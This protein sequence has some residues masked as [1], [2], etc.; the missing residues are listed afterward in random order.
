[1]RAV[2]ASRRAST[3]ARS[4]RSLGDAGPQ[5]VARCDPHGGVDASEQ[6]T[7]QDEC[8]LVPRDAGADGREHRGRRQ[9]GQRHDPERDRQPEGLPAQRERIASGA[10]HDAREPFGDRV[11][12]EHDAEHVEPDGDEAPHLVHHGVS[13]ALWLERREDERRQD[14]A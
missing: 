2:S 5:R 4:A 6:D 12:D 8:R 11:E 3:A 13:D 1:M 7:T 14:D 9:R 10:D